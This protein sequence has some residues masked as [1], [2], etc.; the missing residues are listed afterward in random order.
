MPDF[1]KGSL[2]KSLSGFLRFSFVFFGVN[3]LPP[4]KDGV[5]FLPL[6]VCLSARLL[7]K[8]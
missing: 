6:S 8:L 7:K 1:V 4:L 2:S 3:I 5:T